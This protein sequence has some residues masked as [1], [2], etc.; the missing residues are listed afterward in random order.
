MDETY[1]EPDLKVKTRLSVTIDDLDTGDGVKTRFEFFNDS[2][3]VIRG[4]VIRAVN[5]LM[6]KMGY[7]GK[8][9]EHT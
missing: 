4:Q 8:T 2:P 5:L 1:E 6:D 7:L 3:S 9:K